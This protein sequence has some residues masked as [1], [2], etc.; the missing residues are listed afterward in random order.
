MIRVY[1]L[2]SR[3]P[4]ALLVAGALRLPCRIGKAGATHDKREGDGKSPLAVMRILGGFWRADRRLRPRCGVNLRPIR[5]GDGWCD[6][7]GHSAYNRPVR[8]P[9]ARSHEVMMRDDHQYD[10]VLDLDWNRTQRRQG[11]GSAIFLHVMSETGASSVKAG[12]SAGGTAGC[13]ALQ[14]CRIDALLAVIGPR[15]RIVIR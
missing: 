5:R 6:A 11:R 4:R 12:V 2:E 3:G 9:F 8:L 10:V 13:V 1:R 7:S 14:P 15:T